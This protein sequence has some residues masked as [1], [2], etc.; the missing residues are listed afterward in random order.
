MKRALAVLVWCVWLIPALLRGEGQMPL[1]E[2]EFL[3]KLGVRPA[4]LAAA[5]PIHISV[6]NAVERI[7]LVQVRQMASEAREPYSSAAYFTFTDTAE[8]LVIGRRYVLEQQYVTIELFLFRNA[9]GV[10]TR[11]AYIKGVMTEPRNLVLPSA[12]EIEPKVEERK[13]LKE[14]GQK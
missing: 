1:Y 11:A 12:T 6:K 4:L 7:G 3:S 10:F 13:D 9:D 5:E 14:T 8:S 2:R